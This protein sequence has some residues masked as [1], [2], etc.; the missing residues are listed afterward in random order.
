MSEFERETL[1]DSIKDVWDH[2]S[3]GHSWL[4][5]IRARLH[6]LSLIV[7]AANEVR[8]AAKRVHLASEET[9]SSYIK[10]NII[11]LSEAKKEYE[12][13]RIIFYRKVRTIL[14]EAGMIE[15]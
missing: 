11:R 12:G 7:D 1:P 4:V 5:V 13:L 9:K 14:K 15:E 10:E 8:E 2:D 3:F 6:A